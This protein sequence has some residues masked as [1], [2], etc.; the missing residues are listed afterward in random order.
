[1][2]LA[3]YDK[4]INESIVRDYRYYQDHSTYPKLNTQLT[5]NL[6][7]MGIPFEIGTTGTTANSIEKTLTVYEKA[8]GLT[9]NDET[10]TFFSLLDITSKI[11]NDQPVILFCDM[12]SE[13]FL[14]NCHAIVW[15]NGSSLP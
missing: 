7:E 10:P 8:N 9:I 5:E 4:T 13:E 3:Y 12:G 14:D 2:M 6:S 11:D 1:M 15:I